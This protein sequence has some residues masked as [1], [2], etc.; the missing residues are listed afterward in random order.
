MTRLL[1]PTSAALFCRSPGVE[2][3]G[4]FGMACTIA[5]WLTKRSRFLRVNNASAA[6]RWYEGLG[7][8][9]EWNA[10]HRLRVR[11]YGPSHQ[12]PQMVRL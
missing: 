12:P 5:G 11:D 6:V 8:A 4:R 1:P 9:K 7:Y 2:C 3:V 10:V